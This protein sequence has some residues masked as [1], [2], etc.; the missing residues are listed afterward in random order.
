MANET[1]SA[2]TPAHRH[3]RPLFL[4]SW[5]WVFVVC[6]CAAV[7]S[8]FDGAAVQPAVTGALSYA[9]PQAEAA[10]LTAEQGN[11]PALSLL[12]DAVSAE[13][14]SGALTLSG[15]IQNHSARDYS[16]AQVNFNLYDANGN[17]I[18]T[19][20]DCISNLKPSTIWNFSAT[21]FDSQSR[22]ASYEL[23][24]IICW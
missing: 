9:A 15:T 6:I 4:N 18:G 14:K 24:D 10:L 7:T 19:A 17:Q 16:Y 23:A 12:D 2:S 8:T 3:D 11:V 21:A 20:S 13:Q 5:F 1:R 22:A